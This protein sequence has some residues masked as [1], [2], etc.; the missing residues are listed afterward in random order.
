MAAKAKPGYYG[1]YLSDLSKL[2]DVLIE[3][4]ATREA[5]LK[6]A[7]L[8]NS[9]VTRGDGPYIPGKPGMLL[10]L[11]YVERIRENVLSRKKGQCTEESLPDGQ[12]VK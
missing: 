12:P 6:R 2:E 3:S 11:Y 5:A 9:L 4:R 10:P 7:R 8:L 1:V